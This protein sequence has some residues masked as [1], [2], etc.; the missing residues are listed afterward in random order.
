MEVKTCLKNEIKP[1]LPFSVAGSSRGS[2]SLIVL[3]LSATVMP[4]DKQA[5]TQRT[6]N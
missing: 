2:R 4:S 3:T 6:L 1:P 5:I